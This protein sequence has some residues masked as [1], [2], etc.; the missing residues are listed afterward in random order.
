MQWQVETKEKKCVYQRTHY[1]VPEDSPVAAGKTFFIDEMYRWGWCVVQSDTKPE[2]HPTDPYSNP[3]ELGDYD[4]EDQECD[5]GCSLEFNYDEADDWTDEEK[6]YIDG[7]WQQDQWCAFD[8]N[9]ICS[10]DCDVH[11]VG[12]L[13]VTCLEDVG[14]VE[15][16]K[17]APKSTW[18]F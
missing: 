8:E 2:Q 5:D 3:F 17:P 1:M 12:P 16:P 7:L 6:Q 10:V 18:P 4:V 14:E 13:E 15:E 11:Y 9:G